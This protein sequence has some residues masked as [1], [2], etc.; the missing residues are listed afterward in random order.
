VTAVLV[1]GLALDDAVVSI[2]ALS[3]LAQAVRTAALQHIAMRVVRWSV[4]ME[5]P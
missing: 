3:F 5:P 4:S 1:V 2:A